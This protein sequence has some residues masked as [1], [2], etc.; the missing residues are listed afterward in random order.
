MSA[1]QLA[2]PAFQEVWFGNFY[3][4]ESAYKYRLYHLIKNQLTESLLAHYV[5]VV[6]SALLRNIADSFRG[7]QVKGKNKESSNI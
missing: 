6:S 2:W 3:L 7:L 4:M 5:V 1:R